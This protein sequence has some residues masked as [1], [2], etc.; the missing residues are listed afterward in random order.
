MLQTDGQFICVAFRCNVVYFVQ[1]CRR[2]TGMK[3][4]GR[5]VWLR[6]SWRDTELRVSVVQG[7]EC[8]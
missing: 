4:N 1:V 6:V 8:Q 3:V 5:H 7:E 2:R